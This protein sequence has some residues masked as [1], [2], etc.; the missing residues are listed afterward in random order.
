MLS[1]QLT[2]TFDVKQRFVLVSIGGGRQDAEPL[3]KFVTRPRYEPLILSVSDL[4]LLSCLDSSSLV[5]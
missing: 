5:A 2:R 1:N 3:A 4:S